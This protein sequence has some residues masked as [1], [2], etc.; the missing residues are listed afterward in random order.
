MYR[1]SPERIEERGMLRPWGGVVEREIQPRGRYEPPFGGRHPEYERGHEH[2]Y[3]DRRLDESR[4]FRGAPWDRDYDA[5][6]SGGAT[7]GPAT[8]GATSGTTG[9]SI[10]TTASGGSAAGGIDPLKRSKAAGI[11][12]EG[13][14]LPSPETFRRFG[15][16]QAA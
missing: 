13:T 6:G 12:E 16:V 7:A 1:W 4:D 5:T 15:C 2:G 10:P 9:P 3:Y 8:A 14:V 11:E